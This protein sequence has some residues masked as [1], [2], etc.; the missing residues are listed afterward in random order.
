MGSVKDVEGRIGLWWDSAH[1]ETRLAGALSVVDGAYSLNLGGEANGTRQAAVTEYIGQKTWFGLVAGSAV[2][3]I[4]ATYAAGREQNLYGVTYSW[5]AVLQ[6]HL[7]VVGASHVDGERHFN[8][9]S[10]TTSELQKIFLTPPTIELSPKSEISSVALHSSA[11]FDVA[12]FL[13][14]RKAIF[15]RPNLNLLECSMGQAG[16]KLSFQYSTQRSTSMESGAA[17]H[18][19]PRIVIDFCDNKKL[20]A[21]IEWAHRATRLLSLTSLT[22][23]IVA[24]LELFANGEGSFETWLIY[25]GR[26]K[27]LAYDTE[28]H[29]HQVLVSVRSGQQALPRLVSSWFDTMEDHIVARWIFQ[30]TLELGFEFSINRFLNVMQCLEILTQTHCSGRIFDQRKFREFCN[31]IEQKIGEHE[32]AADWKEMFIRFRATA[33]RQSFAPR[34]IE[35]AERLQVP[36]L[37]HLLGDY[38]QTLE[39]AVKGRNYFTHFGSLAEDKKE[40]LQQNMALLTCKMTV[41]YV[42]A[43]CMLMGCPIETI[44]DQNASAPE[45]LRIATHRQIFTKIQ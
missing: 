22:P 17:F 26:E 5:S 39:F 25:K 13:Q 8:G 45:L 34:L 4:D 42:F 15:E 14:S 35:L 44:V 28:L 2:S 12:T 27:R 1:P 23:N 32:D 3:L 18:H 19:R 9:C 6:P 21:A 29:A 24:D 33:N 36:M 16:G 43:E 40:L 20:Y 38:R 37:A 7:V 11:D 30:N 10:F 31:S 41:L